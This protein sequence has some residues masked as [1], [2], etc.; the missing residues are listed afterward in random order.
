MCF[1]G[2][3][4]YTKETAMKKHTFCKQ[5]TKNKTLNQT[6]INNLSHLKPVITTSCSL[7]KTCPYMYCTKFY[8][9]F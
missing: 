1:Q 6:R 4:N 7:T 9:E 2:S 3:E 8:L 5:K